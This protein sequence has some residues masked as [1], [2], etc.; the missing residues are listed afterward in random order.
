LTD[1]SFLFLLNTEP[2][3]PGGQETLLLGD[4]ALRLAPAQ[5]NRPTSLLFDPDSDFLAFPKIFCGERMAP[6]LN[7]RPLSYA[8]LTKS[9]ARRFD[10]RCV[11]RTDYLLFMD[12]K[13][14]LL[15]MYSGLQTA[16]RKKKQAMEVQ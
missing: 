13:R 9:M 1:I 4:E 16:L 2:I 14:Q 11:S 12:R 8:E 15:Q 10:R 7:N 5:G 3:N 6:S